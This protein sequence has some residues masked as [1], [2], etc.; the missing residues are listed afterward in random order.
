MDSNLLPAGLQHET[1]EYGFGLLSLN[2]LALAV[3]SVMSFD[4]DG[5]TQLFRGRFNVCGRVISQCWDCGD[6]FDDDSAER[7]PFCVRVG[8]SFQGV[9][10]YAYIMCSGCSEKCFTPRK[11]RREK[12][13]TSGDGV[14]GDAVPFTTV[15]SL[16]VTP[17]PPA[18]AS[19]LCHE[20]SETMYTAPHH[21]EE[22]THTASSA[23][24]G[25]FGVG[26]SVFA[27][28]LYVDSSAHGGSSRMSIYAPRPTD[29]TKTAR[30]LRTRLDDPHEIPE[31]ISR[32][33]TCT[34]E[35]T[36]VGGG[37]SL[38][39]LHIGQI[40]VSGAPERKQVS[41]FATP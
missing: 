2:I 4:A 11:A 10:H 5:L 20:D 38:R 18:S 30:R 15:E 12:I 25:L 16:M 7:V 29:L 41:C 27:D 22:M 31:V 35:G 33:I 19:S 1:R 9:C 23:V 17:P 24:F 6:C 8:E 13:D 37:L 26:K 32:S 39:W 28:G 14:S 36:K 40:G 21:D 34:L 3:M